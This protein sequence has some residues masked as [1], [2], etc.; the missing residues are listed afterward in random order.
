[1]FRVHC[2][3][4]EL[5]PE[6]QVQQLNRVAAAIARGKHPVPFRTRKLSPS[7]PMVL[8]G[9]PRG[10]VG[11][12]RTFLQKKSRPPGVGSFLF[13]K[14]DVKGQVKVKGEGQRRRSRS[15]AKS[16]AA[17]DVGPGRPG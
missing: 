6:N 4:P 9:R 2:A 17:L 11:H 14:V 12:R 15:K 5:R 3:V 8:R 7:A 16:K 13:L 1:M 10:R